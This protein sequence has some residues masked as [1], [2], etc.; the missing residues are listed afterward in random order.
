MTV[1][2]KQWQQRA[3]MNLMRSIS[4]SVPLCSLL[5]VLRKYRIHNR[6]PLFS[7]QSQLSSSLLTY[8]PIIMLQKGSARVARSIPQAINR[9]S[10]VP[11]FTSTTPHTP[12]AIPSTVRSLSRSS[13]SVLAPSY[14]AAS[15]ASKTR[16]YATE[17]GTLPANFC[18]EHG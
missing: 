1:A 3:D 5:R 10:V 4:S 8:N 6:R 16:S 2:D 18:H 11:K 14:R 12:R 7:L 17:S 9:A 15:S 13:T